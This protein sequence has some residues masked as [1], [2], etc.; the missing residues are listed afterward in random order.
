[1]SKPGGLFKTLAGMQAKISALQKTLSGAVYEGD[2]ADGKIKVTIKGTGELTMLHVDPAVAQDNADMVADLVQAAYNVAFSKKE[3]A[4]K[5][6]LAG[7]G[8]LPGGFSIPGL[9]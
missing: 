1:M 2:A 3:A 7:L 8:K 6:A 9:G 5:A 4:A